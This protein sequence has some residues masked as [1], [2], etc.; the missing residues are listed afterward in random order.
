MRIWATHLDTQSQ[1]WSNIA[2]PSCHQ[3]HPGYNCVWLEIK[4]NTTRDAWRFSTT[5]N[6]EQSVMTT[7]PCTLLRWC[8]ESWAIWRPSPG[9][10]L[11]SMAKE[12][13]GN[14]KDRV[15][16][17]WICLR[18]FY[19]FFLYLFEVSHVW[20]AF[21]KFCHFCK[22]TYLISLPVFFCWTLNICLIFVQLSYCLLKLYDILNILPTCV[23]VT[24]LF[25]CLCSVLKQS[26]CK[27]FCKR[28][29]ELH[30]FCFLHSFKK[31]IWS[32]VKI[33]LFITI[34]KEN[35]FLSVETQWNHIPFVSSG[36]I[37]FDNLHCTGQEK[38]LSQCPSNGI[39]VS[40]CKH[41]EDV[42]V[43]CSDKRIPGFKFVNTLPNHVE[44]KWQTLH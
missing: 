8:V 3:T 23:Y 35:Y 28:T 31:K 42:G 41:S 15:L 25:C 40:D 37:W 9:L 18:T 26:E 20:T 27:G 43:V 14:L 10:R 12:K 1:S 30:N 19:I 29:L 32:L 11:L 34:I 4:G 13:V 6:G 39:G 5:V 24:G 38:T 21:L 17:H 22:C 36:P 2:P 33:H 44:V 16:F 7:S